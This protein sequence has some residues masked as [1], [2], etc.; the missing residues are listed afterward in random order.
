MPPTRLL[1]DDRGSS[2]VEF[3]MVSGIFVLLASAAV[4]LGM[5]ALVEGSLET[6]ALSASRSGTTGSSDDGITREATILKIIADRTLGLVDIDR[7]EITTKVYPSFDSIGKPEPFTDT[8]GN[9]SRD[10]GEAFQDING[11]GAWDADM[12]AAGLGGPGDVVLYRIEYPWIALTPMLT[13]I[14]GGA[15][16]TAAAAVRNE[17]W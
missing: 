17:P 2:I 11:N 14:V 13:P 6:A 12:G 10:D 7:T 15:T 5:I 8:N 9:G 1:R 16:L 4:E 3:A